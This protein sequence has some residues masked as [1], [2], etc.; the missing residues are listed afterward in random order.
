MLK[1]AQNIQPRAT[2]L[3]FAQGLWV[4]SPFCDPALADW[5]FQWSGEL[6]LQGACEKY[7]LKRAV[8][9]WLPPE[10]VWREK[11]GMGVPLTSWCWQE[12]WRSLGIWLNPAILEAE[13]RWQPDI[14]ARVAFGELG[15]LIQGRR[16]GEILWL[17]MS[18]Q[19][20]RSQVLG[21]SWENLSWNHPFWLPYPLWRLSKKWFQ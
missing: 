16:I 10:I 21:E 9:N 13:G 17:L 1:G 8:E 6:F 12:G 14:A 7:I 19:L 18:W 3:A 4:R 11:R 2:N 5:T 20:W 15:G